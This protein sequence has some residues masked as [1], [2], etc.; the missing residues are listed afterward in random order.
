ML[1]GANAGAMRH[2]QNHR[3]AQPSLR[4][5]AKPGGMVNQLVDARIHE[6]HELDFA[7]GLEPLRR[8]ADADAAD[9]ELRQRHVD[10]ALGPE[11]LLQSDRRPEYAAIHAD[12]F[13]E[14]DH[15]RVILHRPGERQVDGLHQ[16]RLRHGSPPSTH[17]AGKRRP[18]EV[19][20]RGDRTWSPAYVAL[21][22]GSVPPPR[23]LAPDTRSRA[24][25]PPPCPMPS[26]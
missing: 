20:H 25:P 16:R 7:D 19:P 9:Q 5:R 2:A 1:G 4:S 17:R 3:T 11:A 21:S 18:W 26:G 23:R 12:I 24:V 6:T 8:H 13:T 22:P 15:V 10:D 14:H